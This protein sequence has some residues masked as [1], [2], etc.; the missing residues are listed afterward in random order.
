MEQLHYAPQFFHNKEIFVLKNICFS[1][2]LAFDFCF[3]K[4]EENK[5][6]GH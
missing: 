4:D 2:F 5:W 1:A 6:G 3:H